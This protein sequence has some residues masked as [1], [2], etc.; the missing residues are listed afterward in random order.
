[1]KDF[2]LKGD[3]VYSQ[4]QNQLQLCPA[5]Y[6]VCQDGLCRG[7]FETIPKE[8]D[9]FEVLDY[10]QRLILPAMTDLHLHAPQYPNCGM[11]MDL[12]LL[13]WLE[14]YTFPEEQKYNDLNY[15][16]EAYTK[17]IHDLLRS[18]TTRLCAF[19]TIHI[20]STLLLMDMLEDSGLCGCVGLVSMDRNA[21]DDLTSHQPMHELDIWL[22]QLQRF[23]NIKPILTPRFLPSCSDQLLQGIGALQQKT[24][25]PLQSHLSENQ[26]EMEWVA[27][28]V[29]SANSYAE[30]YDSFGVFGSH[31]KTIMA[32]CVHSGEAEI[33]LMKQN[34]IFVAHCPQ[35]N[36][37]LA[38]GIA[39][40]A[41]YLK[42][43]IIVGLGS[44]IAGGHSLSLFRCMA[45]AIAMSKLRWN[46]IDKETPPLTVAQA[47]YMA[48]KGGGSFF[49]KVGS[50][51]EG[52]AF[53]GLVIDEK[54]FAPPFELSMEQRLERTIYLGGSEHI[55]S[56]YCNGKRLF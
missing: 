3:I 23:E 6:V 25:L 35:S 11:G 24:Q 17:L 38:S 18:P 45:D 5:H 33:A 27:Q 43:G 39:P 19:N 9:G 56:K 2:I 41:R 48:T 15:A 36:A 12:E 50:F 51:E 14:T 44:D 40:I 30:A 1:M 34:K 55:I 26:K 22:N 21:P 31:G 16:K 52:Y 13:D 53:D 10:G 47:F 8:F 7:V 20:N 4:S 46:L 29:P 32:H 54:Q 49:G 37:N 28:L 42:E